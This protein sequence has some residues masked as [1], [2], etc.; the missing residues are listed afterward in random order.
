MPKGSV[1]LLLV[2]LLPLTACLVLAAG[3]DMGAPHPWTKAARTGGHAVLRLPSAIATTLTAV[4][5]LPFVGRLAAVASPPAASIALRP[6][7]VPPRI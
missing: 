5:R 7:F 2:I 6:P 4:M 1:V 3:G